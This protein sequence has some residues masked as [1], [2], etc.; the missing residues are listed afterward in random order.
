[1]LQE[2]FKQSVNIHQKWVS[3]NICFNVA[4]PSAYCPFYLFDLPDLFLALLEGEGLTERTGVAFLRRRGLGDIRRLGLRGNRLLALS[5]D[6]VPDLCL[7]TGDLDED[8]RLRI[9]DL[10]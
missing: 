6:W 2:G 7:L 8:C 10:K 4:R 1:M 5:G 3:V 9:G